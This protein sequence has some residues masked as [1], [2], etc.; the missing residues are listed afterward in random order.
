M[1]KGVGVGAERGAGIGVAEAGSDS[2]GV[3]VV[4]QQTGRVRGAKLAVGDIG[5]AVIR[6]EAAES[7]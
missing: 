2:D 3:V 4:G 5:E 1:T 6:G 7:L